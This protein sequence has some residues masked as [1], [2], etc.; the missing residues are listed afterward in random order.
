MESGVEEVGP[1]TDDQPIDCCPAC[2]SASTWVECSFCE[3][4]EGWMDD[5]AWIDCPQ[6]EGT[7]GWSE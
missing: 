7:G 6:C 3:G 5:G 1:V 4:S 2:T